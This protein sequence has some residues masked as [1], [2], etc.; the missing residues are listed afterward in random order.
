MGFGRGTCSARNKGV[1]LTLLRK[2]TNRSGYPGT[3]GKHWFAILILFVVLL[4]NSLARAHTEGPMQLAAAPAG[5][6]KITV[7]TSPDP[8]RVGEIH[9][10]LA[11]TAAEDA[12]PVLDAEVL[13]T[14]TLDDA[15][16][17]ISV[18][19][20]I[21]NS[22]NK[23]LYE[24]IADVRQDGIYEVALLITGNDGAIGEASFEFEVESASRISWYLIAMVIIILAVL[25]YWVWIR[26]TQDEGA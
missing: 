19:A 17:Q 16:K 26:R 25:I 10:A 1:K 2:S 5:P 18:P 22:E 11:V 13:V 14:L 7:W 12:S 15:K 3:L 6:Y 4:N 9:I 8:A 23:F 20:T 21:D 24:A